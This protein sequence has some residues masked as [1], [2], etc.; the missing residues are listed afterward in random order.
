M[1]AI[2]KYFSRMKGCE[3]SPPR[4]P[5]SKIIWSWFGA[6]VGIFA[7]TQLNG[8]LEI[9]GT[10]SIFLIGSFGASAVLLYG[11]PMAELS[12]PRNL[13]FGH[14]ISATVGVSLYYLFPNYISLA[15]ALAVSISIAAMHLTRSL[16]PPAGATALI[17]VIG[18]PKIH[19]LGYWYIVSP[20]LTGA[21]ILLLI[22]LVINNLS[23]NPKRH[24]PRY[25]I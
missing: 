8:I 21:I 2:K 7:I 14:V 11:V 18:A 3:K 10:D 16:H 20:V 22:A 24:Y 9:N 19:Q 17:A 4:K 5:F 13:I 15:C 25:W 1:N 6:F 23:S 12:Q